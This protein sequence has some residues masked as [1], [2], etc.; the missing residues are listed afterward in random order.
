MNAKLL[1]RDQIWFVEKNAKSGASDLYSLA[2]FSPKKG[3]SILNK[4]LYGLYGAIPFLDNGL[5]DG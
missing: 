5:I 4:Y 1:R 2:A 3:D